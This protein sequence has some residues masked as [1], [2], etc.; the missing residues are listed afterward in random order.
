M[1]KQKALWLTILLF[2]LL[3]Q[4]SGAEPSPEGQGA[5]RTLGGQV[6]ANVPQTPE[7][8]LQ[9]FK[10]LLADPDVDGQE[11]CEKR[12]GIDHDIWK[13]SILEK[14]LDKK[15]IGPFGRYPQ[16]PFQF[17]EAAINHQG[18]F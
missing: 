12:L 14:S 7:E 9:V 6:Q 3:A 4:F 13:D 15:L 10:D 5:E 17:V 1:N 16:A 2:L 8:L 18:Y 11:F